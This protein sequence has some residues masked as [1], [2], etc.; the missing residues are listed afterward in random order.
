MGKHMQY[1]AIMIIGI[2]LVDKLKIK[3]HSLRTYFICE[4]VE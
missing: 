1:Y 3:C 4:C 2:I